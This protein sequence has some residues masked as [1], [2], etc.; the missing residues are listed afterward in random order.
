VTLMLLVSP[1]SSPFPSI[2]SP[3]SQAAGVTPST[4]GIRPFLRLL[5]GRSVAFSRCGQ[6]RGS[7]DDNVQ[8][9][10]GFFDEMPWV[11]KELPRQP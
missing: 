4:A 3:S 7:G 1:F 9:K 8:Y 5:W 11:P 10:S 2:L 6:Q